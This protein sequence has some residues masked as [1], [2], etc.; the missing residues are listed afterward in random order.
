MRGATTALRCLVPLAQI[1]SA[2][3]L[4]RKCLKHPKILRQ[5]L[6]SSWE[7]RSTCSPGLQHG[8]IISRRGRKATLRPVPNVQDP[9]PKRLDPFSTR[10]MPS[11]KANKAAALTNHLLETRL[12]PCSVSPV[13][14]PGRRTLPWVSAQAWGNR[15]SKQS[16]APQAVHMTLGRCLNLPVPQFPHLQSSHKHTS[17]DCFED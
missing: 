4:W 6:A 1:T 12:S 7:S 13:S 11:R 2:S 14:L 10:G 15:D 17:Q 16:L 3:P 8:P 9:V 5:R